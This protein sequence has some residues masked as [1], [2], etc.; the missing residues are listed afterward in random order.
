MKI[1]L[2]NFRI[3]IILWLCA[4]FPSLCRWYWSGCITYL[5]FLD[6][7]SWFSLHRK[8]EIHVL[9]D[10]TDF[11]ELR[12]VLK[13]KQCSDK[14]ETSCMVHLCHWISE[15]SKMLRWTY[16]AFWEWAMNRSMWKSLEVWFLKRMLRY[17]EQLR[18]QQCR[19]KPN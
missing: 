18:W 11:R 6:C 9:G 10:W 13:P 2:R 16:S 3:W 8:Y 17:C 5:S 4:T 19:K 7:W 1:I 14:W 15:S 12:K